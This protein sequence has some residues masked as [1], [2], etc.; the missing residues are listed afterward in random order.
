MRVVSIE[1]TAFTA[2]DVELKR[3]NPDNFNNYEKIQKLAKEDNVDL[4]VCKNAESKYLPQHDSYIVLAKQKPKDYKN[5]IFSTKCAIID[6]KTAVPEFSEKI[7]NTVIK[8]VESLGE[9]IVEATGKNPNFL[10]N[11]K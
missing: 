4:W 7:Y 5:T 2:G 1:K 3:L 11:L 9:K 6:K 8:A 10:K